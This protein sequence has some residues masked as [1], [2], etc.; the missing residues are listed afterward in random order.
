MGL[1]QLMARS[2]H[3]DT[4]E[5]SEFARWFLRASDRAGLSANRVAE[6]ADLNPSY[7]YRTLN[8]HNEKY[9]YYKRPSYEKTVD[10]GIALGDLEGALKAADYWQEYLERNGAIPPKSHEAAKTLDAIKHLL[11]GFQ[12]IADDPLSRIGPDVD[13]RQFA[14]L[15][16]F[17]GAASA[18]ESA[19]LGSGDAE[20]ETFGSV[21]H[22]DVRTIRVEGDCMLPFYHHGDILFVRRTE[23]ANHGDI[24]IAELNG[25]VIACKKFFQEGDG[26][27][28]EATNGKYPKIT[29]DFRI[30]GIVK[31]SYRP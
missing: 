16:L 19:H 29:G 13:P 4:R 30:I 9:R 23:V 17:S 1:L 3:K 8:S 18:G 5:M 10:I 11:E 2:E 7:L 22:G 26:A 20:T 27:Y 12:P 31:G 15:P 14:N 28:L 24:V 21:V 25:E 6:K